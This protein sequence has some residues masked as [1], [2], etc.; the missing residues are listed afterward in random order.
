MAT[1]SLAGYGAVDLSKSVYL[2]PSFSIPL[3]F[4]GGLFV[5]LRHGARERL[6][7]ARA[8]TSSAAATCVRLSS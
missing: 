2:Q 8:G 3:M 1:Q 6:R 5:R 7:I 4:G